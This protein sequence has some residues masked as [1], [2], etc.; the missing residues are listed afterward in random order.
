VALPAQPRTLGSDQ[1]A[2]LI[3]QENFYDAEMNPA[4]DF[5]NVLADSGDSGTL[6]D[7]RT[8]LMW[9][10]GGLDLCSFRRMKKKIE[11]LNRAGL[12]GYHDWRLPTLIEAMSLME[13][14][15]NSQGLHLPSCFSGKQPFIFTADRRRPTGYWFVDFARARAYWS[16]G[17]VPGGFGRLCRKSD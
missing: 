16:S 3:K 11:E 12:A 17:T 13:A 7:E 15:L 4:G 8:G 14:V 1:L 2:P 10:R 6:I 5:E 9:Q